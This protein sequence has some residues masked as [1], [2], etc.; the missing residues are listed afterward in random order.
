M[1]RT[2]ALPEEAKVPG[3]SLTK[4]GLYGQMKV[5]TIGDTMET[6]AAILIGIGAFAGVILGFIVIV[7]AGWF[8][9]ASR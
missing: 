7:A 3:V 8:F 4:D 6:F 2:L 1:N 9:Q 5:I